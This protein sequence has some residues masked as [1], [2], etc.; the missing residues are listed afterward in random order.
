MEFIELLCTIATFCNINSDDQ[1]ILYTEKL[2]GFFN[3][4]ISRKDILDKSFQ[5]T[6]TMRI[7]SFRGYNWNPAEGADAAKLLKST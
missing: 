7:L 2:Q 3:T 5:P 1:L 6:T 4:S